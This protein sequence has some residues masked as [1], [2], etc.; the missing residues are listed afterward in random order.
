MNDY[1][2]V[3]KNTGLVPRTLS[4]ANK[5]ADYA[6]PIW[7]C[8]TENGWKFLVDALVGLVTTG[9]VVGVLLSLA[10]WVVL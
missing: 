5:D 1:K 8:E 3:Q 10:Y 6:T 2:Q 7:R 4:E 9:L